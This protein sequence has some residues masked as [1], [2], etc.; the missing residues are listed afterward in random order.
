MRESG[1]RPCSLQPA[2]TVHPGKPVAWL[3]CLAC[4][5]P[6]EQFALV[7][8]SVHCCHWRLVCW[9]QVGDWGREGDFNQ[10]A[11]AAAMARKAAAMRTDF[12]IS[13]GGWGGCV[14]GW[15]WCAS[16]AHVACCNAG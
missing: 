12:V 2:P 6:Q 9:L 10:S 1:G 5:Q 4:S 7:S 11:V 13:T 15:L 16:S 14:G 3:G 8:V